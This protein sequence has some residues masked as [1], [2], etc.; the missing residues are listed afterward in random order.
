MS[1]IINEAKT[2][3]F[4]PKKIKRDDFGGAEEN[5][6]QDAEEITANEEKE[7]EPARKFIYE[8]VEGRCFPFSV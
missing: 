4:K 8:D 3:H 1:D 2:M 6:N 5:S 7:V